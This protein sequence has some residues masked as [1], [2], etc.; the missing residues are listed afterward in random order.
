M[1][2]SLVTG[3]TLTE[4]LVVVAVV[5]MVAAIVI[6]V[7]TTAQTAA[8]ATQCTSRLKQLAT[9]TVLYA[10]D[11]GQVLPGAKSYWDAIAV[12]TTAKT[13]NGLA[14]AYVYNNCVAGAKVSDIDFPAET[15]LLADGQH[16]ATP[17]KDAEPAT[18]AN[19][20]YG[21][22]DLA[23]RH[24][25]ACNVA[26]LDGHVAMT[27]TP[28]PW[29]KVLLDGFEG[30]EGYSY[31]LDGQGDFTPSLK[32]MALS[33]CQD[34]PY[35]GKS[36]LKAPYE[37]STKGGNFRVNFGKLHRFTTMLHG[38]TFWVRDV[39]DSGLK[40]GGNSYYLVTVDTQS[41]VFCWRMKSMKANDDAR[42]P[43][44]HGFTIDC[45]TVT[46]NMWAGNP[47]NK[48]IDGNQQQG[49]LHLDTISGD[50]I[51]SKGT[52]YLDNLIVEVERPRASLFAK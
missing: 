38:A 10:Q 6:P 47:A 12:P 32:G 43:G 16:L 49:Y 24:D 1:K 8:E 4:L 50:G 17:A 52:K 19:V 15:L 27:T 25:G 28:R 44:W 45:D 33:P 40:A 51:A 30:T 39:E 48:M 3:F 22:A 34:T 20:A 42:Q 46:P 35:Q 21:I 7:L 13:E 18:Y 37:F 36:C 14:N 31:T 23:L 11:H 29:I 26:Y 2:R 41:E 9:A 5:T